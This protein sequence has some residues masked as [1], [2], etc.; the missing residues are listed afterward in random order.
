VLDFFV[1]KTFKDHLK[2]QQVKNLIQITEVK[3]IVENS[4][5]SHAHRNRCKNASATAD[6]EKMFF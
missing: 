1:N 6:F 2:M 4:E 5:H 3:R